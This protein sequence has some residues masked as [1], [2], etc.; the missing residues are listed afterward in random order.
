MINQLNTP[1]SLEELQCLFE[2]TVNAIYEPT[3]SEFF[4]QTK[5]HKITIKNP[6][7][8]WV[9]PYTTSDKAIIEHI[10]PN[11][12]ALRQTQEGITVFKFKSVIAIGSCPKLELK[13]RV[14]I[15]TPHIP[16]A[17]LLVGGAF[18]HELNYRIFDFKPDNK[19][20]V[21]DNDD[22]VWKGLARQ[23]IPGMPDINIEN[24]IVFTADITVEELSLTGSVEFVIPGTDRKLIVSIDS[25]NKNCLVDI[26]VAALNDTNKDVLVHI[27]HFHKADQ[28]T[29]AVYLDDDEPVDVYHKNV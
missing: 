3:N 16:T 22:P 29:T 2:E 15:D 11:K 12:P 7:L 10:E 21:L 6:K 24:P 5:T 20:T 18:S 27:D 19:I 25:E 17:D 26:S 4:I 23:G 8:T 9:Q 1:L 14:A 28:L 13:S